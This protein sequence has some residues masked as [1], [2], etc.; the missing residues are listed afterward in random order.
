MPI[1]EAATA[2]RPLPIIDLD[3]EPF[4]D[5]VRN[6]TLVLQRC[7]NCKTYRHPPMPMCPNC[8]SF[9]QEWV[10]SAGRGKV[11]SWIVVRVPSHPFFGQVPYNVVLVEMEEGPRLFSNLLGVE[12]EDIYENMPVQV[13]FVDVEDDFTLFQ[14][15]PVGRT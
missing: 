1:P 12:P 14:F 10:E 13:D 2:E 15:R 8:N 9:D 5:A 6:H 11:H 7:A 4:W 3:S